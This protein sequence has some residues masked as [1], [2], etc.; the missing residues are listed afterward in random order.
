MRPPPSLCSCIRG[1]ESH[2]V[3]YDFL[4][5]AMASHYA[6]RSR[7]R[8]TSRPPAR[9]SGRSSR[10]STHP[11]LNTE[12]PSLSMRQKRFEPGILDRSIGDLLTDMF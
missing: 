11:S 4:A 10:S 9:G 1:S 5:G 6:T 8:T 12:T 7:S 3:F 2:L